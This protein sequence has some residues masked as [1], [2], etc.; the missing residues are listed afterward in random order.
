M[1]ER[2]QIQ[3]GEFEREFILKYTFVNE[4]KFSD[5]NPIADRFLRKLRKSFRIIQK[6]IS[7][8]NIQIDSWAK[9]SEDE[10]FYVFR[11]FPGYFFT[12]KHTK[13]TKGNNT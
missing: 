10:N 12:T 3:G 5:R 1:R 6:E 9:E 4:E 13:I 8:D 7:S 2:I 11:A